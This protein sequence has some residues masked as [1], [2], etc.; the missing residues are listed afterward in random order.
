MDYPDFGIKYMEMCLSI[1][2][3]EFVSA[4]R[5]LMQHLSV[6]AGGEDLMFMRL[7]MGKDRLSH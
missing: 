3:S 2:P 4:K 1:Y 6:P 5:G 7:K